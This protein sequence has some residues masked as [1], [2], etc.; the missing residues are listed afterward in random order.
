MT[1]SEP[2]DKDPEDREFDIFEDAAVQSKSTPQSQLK[3]SPGVTYKALL[4]QKTRELDKKREV[5]HT[6]RAQL[7]SNAIR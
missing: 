1:V 7:Y 6:Y 2:P 4:K 3:S 5:G